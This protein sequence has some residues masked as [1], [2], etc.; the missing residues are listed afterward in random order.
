MH[1]TLL[2]YSAITLNI[3]GFTLLGI[4]IGE[5]FNECW[6]GVLIGLGIGMFIT[7]ILI[8]KTVRRLIAY[9]KK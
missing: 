2:F 9:E 1:K 7:A 3:I 4:G 6:I 5:I 8:L